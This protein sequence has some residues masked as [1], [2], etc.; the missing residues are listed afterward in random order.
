MKRILLIG[1]ISFIILTLFAS[2][3]TEVKKELTGYKFNNQYVQVENSSDLDLTGSITVD[4]Y[5]QLHSYPNSW[6]GVARKLQSDAKNE[7]N[8]RIKNQDVAQWYFGD[9]KNAIVLDW[10]P[11]D[12]LPL[13]EWVRLT[14]VRDLENKQ[15]EIFINGESVA[16]KTFS[17]LPKSAKTD[18]NILLLRHGNRTLDATL[19][20]F[21]IWSKAFNA[22]DINKTAV[23]NKPLKQKD[24]IGFWSFE[25]IEDVGVKVTDLSSSGN[26]AVIIE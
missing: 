8:L 1:S 18:Q 5:L 15:L 25:K 21:R 4:M 11:K 20:E 16:K 17:K 12:V 10:S 2:C 23:V 3:K 14:A 9:G 22:K 6:L 7:F 26:D 13:N 19:S 24:L